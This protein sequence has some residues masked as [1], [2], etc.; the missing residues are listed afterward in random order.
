MP[1]RDHST[2]DTDQV[3]RRLVLVERQ[4]AV[5][6]PRSRARHP[7]RVLRLRVAAAELR[8]ALLRG[9]THH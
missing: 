2:P 7:D 1:K 8:A 6:D 5:M 3:R 9:T 4:L